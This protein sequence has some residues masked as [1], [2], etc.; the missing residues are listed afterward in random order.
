MMI[1]SGA[2][3]HRLVLIRD[4][5]SDSSGRMRRT[6]SKR[7]MESLNLYYANALDTEVYP[8][9]HEDKLFDRIILKRVIGGKT[10]MS[11]KIVNPSR[12]QPLQMDTAIVVPNA[13]L[14]GIIGTPNNVVGS[15]LAAKITLSRISYGIPLPDGKYRFAVTEENK[16]KVTNLNTGFESAVQ[17][18]GDSPISTIVPGINVTIADMTGCVAGDYADVEV[19]GDTTFLIPGT[20]LGRLK[21]G[22]NAGKY[23]VALEDNLANYSHLRVCAGTLETDPSKKR[24]GSDGSNLQV[25]ANTMTVAVY[26]FAQLDLEIVQSVNMTNAMKQ[27]LNGIVWY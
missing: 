8:R 24:I 26:V 1:G 3:P 20:I 15:T 18:K 4:S 25:N 23:E 11:R 7:R 13:T 16:Y 6:F 21:T 14:P 19:F 2:R 5:E 10:Y 9:K 17:S 12:L 27:L 22:T